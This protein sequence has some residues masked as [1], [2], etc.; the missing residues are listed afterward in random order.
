MKQVQLIELRQRETEKR[1]E[2]KDTSETDLLRENMKKWIGNVTDVGT[3]KGRDQTC[4]A[5]GY[6]TNNEMDEDT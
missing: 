3:R 2:L 5:Q 6:A 1:K 4:P